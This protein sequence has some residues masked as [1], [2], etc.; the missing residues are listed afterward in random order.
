M[1]KQ[2]VEKVQQMPVTTTKS[3][4]FFAKLVLEVLDGKGFKDGRLIEYQDP[5]SSGLIQI[6]KD[7]NG[8]VH[9]RTPRVPDSSVLLKRTV[10]QRGIRESVR[11]DPKKD[12]LLYK[13]NVGLLED[14]F[15]RNPVI[16]SFMDESALK[17]SRR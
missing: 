11:L 6:R 14:F 13:G 3:A 17:R 2:T 9:F 12:A 15:E 16:L 1:N 4:N 8:R 5:L 7:A 10:R